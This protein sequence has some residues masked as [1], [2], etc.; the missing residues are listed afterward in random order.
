[1][2]IDSK[3]SK[4]VFTSGAEQPLTP[5]KN[6]LSEFFQAMINYVR[7]RIRQ[8]YLFL[9]AFFITITNSTSAIKQWTVQHMYWGR[10]SLYR[11]V[12]HVIVFGITMVGLLLGISQRINLFKNINGGGLVLASGIVGNYDAFDQEGTAESIT[13]MIPSEK[14]WPEYKHTVVAG[15]TLDNIANLYGVN[16]A[17]IKW[18]NNLDSDKLRINQVLIVPGLNGV[19]YTVTKGDTVQT[20]AKKVSGNV[21][22]I[23]ELNQLTAPDYTL[24]EG[25]QIFIPNGVIISNVSGSLSPNYMRFSDPGVIVPP[26]SFINPLSV[27]CPVYWFVRGLGGPTNHTGYDLAK[28]GGC[29]INAACNGTIEY[30]EWSSDGRGFYVQEHCDNGFITLYYHGSGDYAVNPGDYVKAGQ[31]LM[32]MGSTGHSTGTHLH[33]EMHYNNAIVDPGN[34][35]PNLKGS[36]HL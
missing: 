21:F 7:L 36:L 34:Y 29:W 28:P 33:F 14:N 9:N 31:R 2:E 15:E 25:Q 24:V 22:D 13:Q 23:E 1:V 19:L 10:S 18:A 32:Y 6:I 4:V 11:T 12:F 3:K 17:T 5:Q 8:V 26:G 35:I 27:F 30:A 16:T 20:V